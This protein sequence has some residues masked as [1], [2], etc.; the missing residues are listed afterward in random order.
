M[1]LTGLFNVFAQ[2]DSKNDSVQQT[3][4]GIYLAESSIKDAGWGVYAGKDFRHGEHM[5]RE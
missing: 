1:V 4:C 2:G 5:V 3:T